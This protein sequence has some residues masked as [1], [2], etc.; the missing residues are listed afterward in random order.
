M[1]E[2][3]TNTVTQTRI[4]VYNERERERCRYLHE[5]PIGGDDAA[6]E[7]V[8]EAARQ[9]PQ[10]IEAD[11]E[12]LQRRHARHRFRQ[13]RQLRGVSETAVSVNVAVPV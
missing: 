7:R 10:P 1:T 4:D 5:V 8:R 13:R 2:I 3:K 6:L 11:V 12:F 9:R